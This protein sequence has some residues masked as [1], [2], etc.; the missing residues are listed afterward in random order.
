MKVP[1]SVGRGTGQRFAAGGAMRA[2]MPSW[3]NLTTFYGGHRKD[4]RDK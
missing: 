4:R 3:N 1:G 2:K